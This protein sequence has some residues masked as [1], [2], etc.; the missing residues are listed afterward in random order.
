MSAPFFELAMPQSNPAFKNAKRIQQS[1][2]A[3]LERRALAWLASHTPHSINSDHLTLLGFLSTF[4]V[5]ACYA[6]SRWNKSALFIGIALLAM[7]WLGDSLDGTLARFRDQQ[8]P[9]YGFYVDH[10]VDTFGACFIFAGLALSGFMHPL[11]ALGVLVG[12]LMFSCEVYLATYTIGDFKISY[13][14][15]SPTELRILLAIGNL[16]LFWRPQV[17]LF[18]SPETYRLFDVGGICAMAG[19]AV[20]LV[21]SAVRNTARLHR[22]ETL[23]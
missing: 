16:V 7:N 6:A 22:Q 13:G 11:I 14:L 18:G 1:L 4:G 19:M 8:R 12:F 2:L 23:R 17:H 21:I 3:P 9:R 15:F 20:M 5:G 10:I